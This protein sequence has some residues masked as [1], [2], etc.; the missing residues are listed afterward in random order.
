[1]TP[2]AAAK[3][4]PDRIHQNQA[5]QEVT[6][7]APHGWQPGNAAYFHS[8]GEDAAAGRVLA[9]QTSSPILWLFALYYVATVD[10]LVI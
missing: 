1:M 10:T 6:V 8:N 4:H 9:T 3:W 2:V 5:A 7:P